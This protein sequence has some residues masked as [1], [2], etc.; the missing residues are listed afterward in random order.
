[1]ESVC[2]PMLSRL[3]TKQKEWAKQRKEVFKMKRVEV[4]DAVAMYVLASYYYNGDL[5]CSKIEQTSEAHY[6][7]LGCIYKYG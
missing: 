6:F 3:E 1:V 7:S 4:N 5:V 2:I